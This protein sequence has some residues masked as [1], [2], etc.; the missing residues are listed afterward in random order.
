M[1]IEKIVIVGTGLAGCLAALALAHKTRCAITLVDTGGIDDSLGLPLTIEPTLPSIAQFHKLL[2]L[3]Q[4]RLVDQT[5]SSYTLGRALSNWASTTAASFHPYGGVGASL[6]PV[7]FQH[8]VARLRAE[9]LPLSFANYSIAALCAQSGRFAPTPAEA[10]SVLSTMDF[11][12]HLNVTEYRDQ[13]KRA[14]IACGVTTVAG[15]PPDIALD[16]H[17]LITSLITETGERITG[18]LFIDCSGQSR[19]L[20]GK[21]PHLALEDWSHWLPCNSATANLTPASAPPPL[22][23]HVD[24]HII[25]W[26]R[27]TSTQN[28]LEDIFVSKVDGN[29][30][31]NAYAFT[32][33]RV[34]KPWSG[35]CIAIGGSAAIIDPLAST[36]LHLVG[37]AIQ[38]LLKLFPHDRNCTVEADEYNRQTIE[39]LENARDFAILHYKRNGRVGDS[40]WDACRAMP[41]PE[42]LAHKIALYESCGRVALHDEESFE[43]WDWIAA[44]DA[45]GVRPRGYDAMTNGIP[46]DRIEA[47]LT[48]I[49]SI[50][51]NAVGSL[52]TQQD[53]LQ[54]RKAE[55]A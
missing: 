10:R 41:I 3:D 12:L 51:L 4:E 52:P 30:V 5:G 18:D 46:K 44:L 6:G 50:M 38:R 17:G 1:P 34:S 40:F 31:A 47:H 16:Q 43:A 48:Q 36:Q 39:E 11:G 20:I 8:L 9:G 14:V 15:A 21:L 29:G 27:F 23:A 55:A 28:V 42:R 53:Y 26:Q 49:R 22:Y 54:S 37:T 7:G 32:S 19:L 24:A 13:L 45:L 2:G 25:G 33:G 35:N